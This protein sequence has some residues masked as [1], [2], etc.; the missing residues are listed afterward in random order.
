M[1]VG[2]VVGK[3]MQQQTVGPAES[4]TISGSLMLL[5]LL[6]LLLR[7][8]TPKTRAEPEAK[9]HQ[10]TKQASTQ[11][12]EPSTYIYIYSRKPT[13]MC[14][15]GIASWFAAAAVATMSRPNWNELVLQSNGELW[16][17]CLSLS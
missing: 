6:L 17:F 5:M 16:C 14:G 11:P 3:G 8:Q 13:T 2:R 4:I 15:K 10:N 9:L 1:E 12:G 7:F